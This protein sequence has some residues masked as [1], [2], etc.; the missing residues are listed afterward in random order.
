MIQ[1]L[2]CVKLNLFL[3]TI[4]NIAY[5]LFVVDTVCRTTLG[6]IVKKKFFCL[7]FYKYRF[8]FLI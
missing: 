1:C 3:H 6:R 2:E 7:F 5:M 4:Y 8:L